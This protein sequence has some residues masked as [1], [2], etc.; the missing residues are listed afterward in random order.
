MNTEGTVT[1][2][3]E[4]VQY[5]FLWKYFV[6]FVN[7]IQ[8]NMITT[9]FEN[10]MKDYLVSIGDYSR[11][12]FISRIKGNLNIK[13]LVYRNNEE[14]IEIE[15][16]MDKAEESMV[17]N[18]DLRFDFSVTASAQMR[19]LRFWNALQSYKRDVK[20]RGKS[21]HLGKYYIERCLLCIHLENWRKALIYANKSDNAILKCAVN[22]H[23]KKFRVV[24]D[25]YQEIISQIGWQSID[26]ISKFEVFCIFGLSALASAQPHE[27]YIVESFLTFI[28][29]TVFNSIK[30]PLTSFTRCEYN[31]I[32]P[33]LSELNLLY[34]LSPF[35]NGVQSN[36]EQEIKKN[37]I[38]STISSYS[39]I[40]I[41]KISSITGLDNNSVVLLACENI[42][43]GLLNAKVDIHKQIIRFDEPNNLDISNMITM[44]KSE[45]KN[46]RISYEYEISNKI[47]ST[48]LKRWRRTESGP[49]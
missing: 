44:I 14:E 11:E 32:L 26:F 5:P 43:E 19:Q 40:S 16:A 36:L 6:L 20:L 24:F 42:N 21:S 3:V 35:F 17:K 18:P 22:F 8:N 2:L 29:N 7:R 37:I 10:L 9:Y 15:K 45:E 27:L 13:S 33:A 4:G 28:D 46:F 34:S 48:T 38:R 12:E 31:S 25:M 30:E 23:E 39:N 47:R 49:I 41:P 1:L